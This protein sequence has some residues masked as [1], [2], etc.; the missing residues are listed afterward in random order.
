MRKSIVLFVAAGLLVGCA[1]AAAEMPFYNSGII[2]EMGRDANPASVAAADGRKLWKDYQDQIESKRIMVSATGDIMLGRRVGKL[3][4][5]NGGIS[6]YKNFSFIFD[7]SDVLFGNLECSLSERGQRLLGKGIWLRGTP[8][9][10]ELLKEA[11]FSILSLA[12]NHILDY[13]NDALQDTVDF[14]DEKGIGHAG[15]GMDISSAREPYIFDKGGSSIGF[16]AYNEFSY[17]F[18]SYEEKRK[19]V[20]EENM[21]GTA[22]TDLA[23]ML[24]DIEKLKSRVDLVAVSLHWG[25]EESNSET[26]GQREMAH[27]LIDAGADIIIGHHPHV[28]QGL[29]IY[30]ERPIIYSLGNYIFDQNDENNK[31]GMVA[32]IETFGGKIEAISLHP[33]YVKDKREPI[34]PQ[35]EKLEEVLG[36]IKRLSAEMGTELE[37]RGNHLHY[38]IGPSQ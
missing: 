26:E 5:E 16:L 22:P 36:K 2:V 33:L 28:I 21:P 24:E 9:K 3:L 17:Y 8:D 29:E 1:G 27:A 10:A 7:R 31:Q 6:A 25:I 19:F 12:N 13:G 34:V 18:W 32:E 14:L 23:P 35:G 20:A 38:S 37:N 15:A 11:G 30:R 4:D